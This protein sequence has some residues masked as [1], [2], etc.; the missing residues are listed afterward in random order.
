M[1]GKLIT[2]NLQLHDDLM[3]AAGDGEDEQSSLF[4]PNDG[5]SGNFSPGSRSWC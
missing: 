5:A 4:V 3:G 2:H 1:A